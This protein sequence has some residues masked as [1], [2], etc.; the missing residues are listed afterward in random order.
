MDTLHESLQLI[1]DTLTKKLRMNACTIF[2][3]K[4]YYSIV[5]SELVIYKSYNFTPPIKQNL[6]CIFLQNESAN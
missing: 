4:V 3:S 2:T 5:R 6:F 1:H